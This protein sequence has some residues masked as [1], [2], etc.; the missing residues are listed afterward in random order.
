MACR[1]KALTEL[2]KF[3]ASSAYPGKC[4]LLWDRAL[5]SDRDV[6]RSAPRE[7]VEILGSESAAWRQEKRETFVSRRPVKTATDLATIGAMTS[8]SHVIEMRLLIEPGVA[9]SAGPRAT[10]ADISVAMRHD[11]KHSMADKDQAAAGRKMHAH[12]RMV[13]TSL[14][15][16][17]ND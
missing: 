2:R 4:R 8:P 3:L 6:S 17:A 13:R 15:C 12:P 1:D 11:Q 5:C 7:A 9:R 10:A 14:L 16:T